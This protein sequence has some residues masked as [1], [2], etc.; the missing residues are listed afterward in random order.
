MILEVVQSKWSFTL[1][2][3]GGGEV[4]PHIGY[5]SMCRW[6]GYGFQAIWSG[7]GSSNHRKLVLYR[8]PLNG[9][10]AHERLKSRTIEHF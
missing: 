2:D 9:S 3:R 5:T 10:I 8:V 4:L 1:C 7:I 6:K